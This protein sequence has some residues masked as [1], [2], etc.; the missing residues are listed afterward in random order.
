MAKSTSS[1]KCSIWFGVLTLVGLGTVPCFLLPE[2]RLP[3]ASVSFVQ[4]FLPLL[5][6]SSLC[7]LSLSPL[8]PQE[9]LPHLSLTFQ[10]S[11]L[12]VTQGPH[13]LYSQTE[14][15]LSFETYPE[16]SLLKMGIHCH[17]RWDVLCVLIPTSLYP[18]TAPPH[19]HP[20]SRCLQTLCSPVTSQAFGNIHFVAVSSLT[21][22]TTFTFKLSPDH[23]L[24]THTIITFSRKRLLSPQCD[25]AVVP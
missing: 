8:F 2:I 13:S 11:S 3:L 1:A 6:S 14:P 4:F 5:A 19:P 20:R 25:F 15:S 23:P 7:F 18:F 10:G 21:C 22:P 17:G 24:K 16:I 12:Q 9:R